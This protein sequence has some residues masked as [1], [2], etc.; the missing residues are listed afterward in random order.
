MKILSIVIAVASFVL[1]V[2]YFSGHGPFASH[3]VHVTHGVLFV[4]IGLLALVWF[5]FQ[6]ASTAEQA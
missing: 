5:R 1:A 6:S 3:K 2:L 4:V